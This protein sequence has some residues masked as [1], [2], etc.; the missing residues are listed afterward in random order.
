[1]CVCMRLYPATSPSPDVLWCL[2]RFSAQGK[3]NCDECAARGEGEGERCV[4]G[5]RGEG[6]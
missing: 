1:M 3:I 6:E 4:G 5:V 2:K